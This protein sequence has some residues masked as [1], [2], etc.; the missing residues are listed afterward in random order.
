MNRKLLWIGIICLIAFCPIAD[1]AHAQN[2]RPIVR[3]IYFLP[4]DR[5]PQ[6]D[7]DAKFDK[8]IKDVQQLYANQME[9]HGF[10]RKTFQF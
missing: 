1:F 4:K 5:K 9:A 10:G 6:P 3:L 7:I 2:T 8:W